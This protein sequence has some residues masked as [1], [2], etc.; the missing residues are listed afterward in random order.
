VNYRFVA[1]PN[2][3]ASR[4]G[5]AISLIVLHYTASLSIE[6]TLAW[7]ANPAAKASAHYVIGRDGEVVQCVHEEAAAWHAGL[8]ALWQR[9]GFVNSRSVGIELV[10]TATSGYTG[11]QLGALW[12]L[13]ADL[14]RRYR[15]APEAVIGHKDVL[16]SQKIDP[17]GLGHQFPWEV[18]RA[19]A[20]AA[21]TNTAVEVTGGTDV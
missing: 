5:H 13:L 18:A 4:Q 17:D 16:P 8:E 14:V 1:S 9:L 10:A 15:I 21:L 3:R 19:V 7:F 12:T 11:P 20:Q 2:F 6:G